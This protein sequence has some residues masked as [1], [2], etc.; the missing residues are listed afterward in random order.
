M[1]QEA[2]LQILSGVV[3]SAGAL[4]EAEPPATEILL[5][6][7][8]SLP[9]EGIES[10]YSII[11]LVTDISDVVARTGTKNRVIVPALHTLCSILE[12]ASIS[13][14]I[15]KT[16]DAMDTLSIYRKCEIIGQ[17]TN[18]QAKRDAVQRA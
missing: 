3:T 13:E 5:D 10:N 14:I 4:P 9:I 6:W 17:R 15:R 2:R 11:T 8:R 16:T 7:A 18:V 1:P 12:D